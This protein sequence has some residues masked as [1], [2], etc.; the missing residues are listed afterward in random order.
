MS[1][2]TV[3]K[4]TKDKV[5]SFD[6]ADSAYKTAWEAFEEKYQ[7]EFDELDKLREDRNAK[8]DAAKR[9]LREEAAEKDISEVKF[10][11][12]SAFSVQKK[13]SKFYSEKTIGMLKEKGLWDSA[14]TAKVVEEKIAFAEFDKMQDFFQREGVLKD[15]EECEDGK[16]LTP[17]VTAPYP[18]P[19]FGAETKEKK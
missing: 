6:Q 19:A 7:A 9:A 17:A 11:K 14:L 13:F 18:V 16:E 1:T 4:E 5:D 2:P 8:L 10:I 3:S 15:F 12:I